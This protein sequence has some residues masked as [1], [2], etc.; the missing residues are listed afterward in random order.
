MVKKGD[1]WYAVVDGT[2]SKLSEHRDLKWDW[3]QA[4]LNSLSDPAGRTGG[5]GMTTRLGDMPTTVL[6]ALDL[7]GPVGDR[8]MM[9]LRRRELVIQ[10][11]Q[12][13]SKEEEKTVSPY[14]IPMNPVPTAP[15]KASVFEYVAFGE[16]DEGNLVLLAEGKI[17]CATYDK[18]VFMV[19]A[20]LVEKGVDLKK[21][22]IQIRC[23][24]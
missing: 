13:C 20:A 18:A 22:E 8:I 17:V 11:I 2:H 4:Y 10:D 1:R 23:F 24:N 21:A 15:R 14:D 6:T 19:G 7:G 5:P 16:D 9:E 3:D 12:F